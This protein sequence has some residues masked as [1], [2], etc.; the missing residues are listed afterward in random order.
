MGKEGLPQACFY[1]AYF[2]CRELHR[3]GYNAGPQAGTCFWPRISLD[4]PAAD[5]DPVATFGFQYEPDSVLS[6]LSMVMGNLPEVHVWCGIVDTQEIVD[7]SVGF[8]PDLGRMAGLDWP[9][10]KPPRYFWGGVDALPRGVVYQPHLLA[11][12]QVLYAIRTKARAGELP[13]EF[14]YRAPRESRLH[15]P[16]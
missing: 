10:P 13:E 12:Y 15:K 6:R 3:R 11:S 7:L 2:A 9:G 4:D 1:F 16:S 5:Q 14:Y 8:L